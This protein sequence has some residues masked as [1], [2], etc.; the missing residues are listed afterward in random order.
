MP[1]LIRPLKNETS[2]NWNNR[3]FTVLKIVEDGEE[4]F[5][6][7]KPNDSAIPYREGCSLR[8]NLFKN[9]L[10]PYIENGQL[11]LFE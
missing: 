5:A 10:V 2:K 1:L 7:I 11:E 9:Y 3:I 8:T 4:W 6:E